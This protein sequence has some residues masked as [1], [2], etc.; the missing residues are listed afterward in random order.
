MIV[1]A[2]R[3]HQ[4]VATINDCSMRKT[5]LQ[6]LPALPNLFTSFF[7]GY[8]SSVHSHHSN[9]TN[10]FRK[11]MLLLLGC[12][13]TLSFIQAQV[14]IGTTTPNNSAQLDVQSTSKGLLLPRMTAA[15]RA[16]IP[17]PAQGLLVYQTDGSI[18]IYHYDGSYWR[19][20]TTGFIPNTTG[21][22]VAQNAIVSTISAT[23]NAIG[24]VVGIAIDKDGNIYLAGT[25]SHRVRKVTPSGTVTTLA[26]NG[27]AG[28]QDGLAASAQFN[29]PQ[30]IAVDD[31]G[32][33]YVADGGN[34]RI[35]KIGTDGMVTTVAGT[36]DADF[37]D[38]AGSAAK[39]NLP[40]GITIDK[41]GT[42]YVS[43]AANNRIRKITISG[44]NSTVTTLAGNGVEGFA[45]GPA[46]TTA[47]FDDP[48]GLT[49]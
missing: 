49:V 10:M 8:C 37:L 34:N 17:N 16:A 21:Q 29:N 26:G 18:G 2:L 27:N 48:Y 9:T 40:L 39:F 36:G 1:D 5:L 45:D 33:V 46:L 12:I 42:L 44:S 13:G 30:G 35:R 3:I 6:A 14:G 24:R 19:S 41:A 25:L 38:G 7:Q 4:F 31:A 11:I 28:Y 23:V 20:L 47:M 22:A 43:D 32:N 15:Q